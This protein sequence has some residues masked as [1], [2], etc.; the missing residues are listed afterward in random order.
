MAACAN[1]QGE[2]V[3]KFIASELRARR[4][5]ERE[6]RLKEQQQQVEL[7]CKEAEFQLK[8]RLL[9][10]RQR[11]ELRLKEVEIQLRR[12][13]P[14]HPPPTGIS[15]F[16][17]KLPVFD[18]AK[19]DLDTFLGRFERVAKLQKW[20]E[21]TWGAQLGGQLVGR[22]AEVYLELAEEQLSDYQLVKTALR[23]AFQL[24][25][26]WYRRQFRQARKQ[27]KETFPQFATRLGR[28]VDKWL[29][30]SGKGR[31]F[32]DMRDLVLQE[33]L[34]QTVS[35]EL[36]T[37]LRQQELKDAKEVASKAELFVEARRSTRAGRSLVT[38]A[39]H[40]QD[41]PKTDPDKA[42]KQKADSKPSPVAY[43]PDNSG[44]GLCY[45]C[46]QPGHFKRDCPERKKKERLTVITVDSSAPRTD[47]PPVGFNPYCQARVGDKE[48]TALRDTGASTVVVDTSL[49][50]PDQML[51]LQRHVTLATK[52]DVKVCPTALIQVESPFYC[53]E[54]LA[55][56]L[57]NLT[58]PVILGNHAERRDGTL[59]PLPVLKNPP[60][61]TAMVITRSQAAKERRSLRPLK[62]PDSS[63]GAV[64]R[65]EIRRLQQEDPSLAKA[66][67][68]A[69]A[70]TTSPSGKRGQIRFL[71]RKG[72]LQREYA[73][74][75]GTF[76]QVCVPE[77]LRP[78]LLKLSHDV[79]MAGHLGSKK[80]L[81]RL[82]PSFYWPAQASD[83]RRYVASCDAC[84]R[85]VPRGRVGKVPLGRHPLI[86]E[87]FRRVGVDLVGP[88]IPASE[89][90][91]R[92]I[93]VA[94]DYAT[95]YPEA[96]PLPSIEAE[97][98]AEALWEM[99]T[100][101]G[102]PRE[103]LTDNGT[104]FV[105]ELMQEVNRLLC[106]RGLTT[107]PYHAQCNGLVERF[108][109]TLKT[110]LRKLCQDRP[111][112]WDRFIPALLFA[113][114]EVPQDSL[115][116][117]P[118]E[119]LYG[120]AVRGPLQILKEAWTH[121]SEEEVKT[122][123]QY[124]LD[125]RDRLEAMSQLAQKNLGRSAE[126]YAAAFDRKA[127]P[128][129]FAVGS[130]VLLLLPGKKNKLEMAWQG[131]YEVIER[132]GEVDYRIRAGDR[133]RLFHANLLK[134]YQERDRALTS[135]PSVSPP[136]AHV[137][138]VLDELPVRPKPIPYSQADVE[139]REVAAMLKMGVIQRASSPYSAPIV[140]PS[141]LQD[142]AAVFGWMM[143]KL[144]GTV[145]ASFLLPSRG[146]PW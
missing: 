110:M 103:V 114:R 65:E 142:A 134:A 1:L 31:T 85:T 102:V 57:P 90:K 3:S 63:L 61:E 73:G 54:A 93:L 21:D 99:W 79:P 40:A 42:G 22:A 135:T 62:I 39:G 66:R 83:V 144:L 59:V 32:D 101:L 98:V 17:M 88:I 75:D 23:E 51:P 130:R 80:T 76:H 118:F 127:K 15:T 115:G 47:V 78:G 117:S 82:Q 138:V 27:E 11:E 141:G 131:P 71:W 12:E 55:I 70:G 44:K 37:F 29:A 95:R 112:D 19:E 125:L 26:E 34:L 38:P 72:V 133:V 136:A 100:R 74:P 143:R 104:Q 94:V 18:E 116:F 121:D 120:R 145:A 92:Y 33:Q 6:G 58:V 8:L 13:T 68:L 137:A 60:R 9:E 4:L 41:K 97:R 139:K 2:E 30:L 48:V 50:H 108:N 81:N 129:H 56:V 7:Q 146:H 128:R 10:E 140:L 119:L 105:S 122:S 36:A 52:D 24:T 87:P 25:G 86:D 109:G 69:N 77:Q 106:I 35:F 45:L 91:N 46:H 67:D 84:Q 123:V 14:A 64:T 53:G 107:T 5:E 16:K 28:L 20:P 113:Y 96:T 132:V 49:V 89:R 126:R 43:L 124:V 111:R